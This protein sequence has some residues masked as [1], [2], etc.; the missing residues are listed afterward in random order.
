MNW[1]VLYAVIAVAS[2][3]LYIWV[4]RRCYVTFRAWVK[5]VLSSIL[6]PLTILVIVGRAIIKAGKKI[7]KETR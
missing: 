1:I 3:L 4:V 5:F 6:W 7:R 2:M